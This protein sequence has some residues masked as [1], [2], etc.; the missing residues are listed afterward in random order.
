MQS[1]GSSQWPD[2]QDLLAEGYRVLISHVD[3][4]YLDCGFGRWRETGEAACDPYR[5]WQTF[6]THRPWHQLNRIF[7][8][9]TSPNNEQIDVNKLI[10][11]GEVCLWSEQVEASSLD[12]RIWPRAAAFAE[13][14]WSDPASLSQ[15]NGF[16]F[17]SFEDTSVPED[18]YTRL[19]TH[20]ERLVGRGMM[21]E[22]MWP[23]WCSHNAGMCL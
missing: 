23:R 10:I 22:A 3:A 20:R 7:S 15:Q 13:R 11:G 9:Q 17:S 18:V 2:T 19:S 1:W 14:M 21:A 16:G 12:A 4:W 6:Y 5:P 8:T